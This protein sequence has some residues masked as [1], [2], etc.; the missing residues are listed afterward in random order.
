MIPR[1]VLILV[2]V[3]MVATA[4]ALGAFLGQKL[5]TGEVGQAPVFWPEV[6][7]SLAAALLLLLGQYVLA[8][9]QWHLKQNQDRGEQNQ[10]EVT[11]LSRLVDGLREDRD[12]IKREL[13]QLRGEQEISRAAKAHD[14][15]DGFIGTLAA[16]IARSLAGAQELSIFHLSEEKMVMPRAHYQ[17]YRDI[18]LFIIFSDDGGALLSESMQHEPL[19]SSRFGIKGVAL[20]SHNTEYHITAALGYTLPDRTRRPVGEVRLKLPR[21]GINE[22]LSK[23]DA[24]NRLKAEMSRILID[25][26]GVTETLKR[27][28]IQR[29]DSRRRM[30][31]LACKLST[32]TEYFGVIKAGFTTQGVDIDEMCQRWKPLL[33]DAA[34]HIA[35]AMH[36]HGFHMRA[37]K[38]GM[39]GLYNK[40]YTQEKLLEAFDEARDTGMD[41]SF[42]MLDIDK[43]KNVNDTYGH[44]TGDIIIIG[45]AKAMAEEARAG[46]IVFR[47]GG[48]EMGFILAG[49]N[50]RKA[51]TLANRVRKKIEAI[52]FIG[53]HQERI[54]CT[55]SLGVAHYTDD[56]TEPQD[57]LSRSDQ[58]LY[59]S[60]EN[61]RNQSTAYSAKIVK[62]LAE[63]KSGAEA[64]VAAETGK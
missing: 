21:Q 49:Q 15:L 22:E 51:L 32:E 61:G 1:G 19:P 16:V 33:R 28:M 9:L 52:E 20:T 59:F 39:T 25:G 14:S 62:A 23:T 10:Y 8:R 58:A 3:L 43:F 30:L 13:E 17:R 54:H 44:I 11:S 36:T 31:E 34:K 64:E 6:G 47:F 40:Q 38:D 2:R 4:F 37:I 57:L 42:I 26:T 12:R 45:V 50:A 48:E 56:M 35:S 41:L 53:E 24:S 5:A 60:K 29:L 7:V 27:P 63:L 18:E 55:V 46:D